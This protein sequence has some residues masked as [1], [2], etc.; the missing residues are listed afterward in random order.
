MFGESDGEISFISW[1]QWIHASE[2]QQLKL[3]KKN[4]ND[5]PLKFKIQDIC[6]KLLHMFLSLY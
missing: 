2:I 3:K 6:G 4:I 5:V 1:K